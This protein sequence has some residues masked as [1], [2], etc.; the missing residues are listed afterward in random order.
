MIE[1]VKFCLY[2]RPTNI[3]C[4]Q[5]TSVYLRPEGVYKL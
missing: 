4:L 5:L 2:L 3:T 1:V